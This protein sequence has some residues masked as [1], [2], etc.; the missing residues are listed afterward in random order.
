M[1]KL[2]EKGREIF[3]GE[4]RALPIHIGRRSPSIHERIRQM[5]LQM[6]SVEREGYETFEDADDFDVGDDSPDK[7]DNLPNYQRYEYEKDFDHFNDFAPGDGDGLRTERQPKEQSQSDGST[8][9][10]GNP[11]RSKVVAQS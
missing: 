7:I 3:D 2:D 8:G 5:I 1:S 9:D 6:K 4:V 11:D 10:G